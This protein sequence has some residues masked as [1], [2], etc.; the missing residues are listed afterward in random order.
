MTGILIKRGSL[1]IESC[2]EGK[3]HVKMKAESGVKHLQAKECQRLPANHQKLGERHGT[4]FLT[5]LRKNQLCQHLDLR[6][7]ASR[8]VT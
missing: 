5:I 3:H 6:L 8:T 1:D 7:L 4:D 2:P